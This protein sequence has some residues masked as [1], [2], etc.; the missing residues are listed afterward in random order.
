MLTSKKS[1]ERKHNLSPRTCNVF[2]NT[3]KEMFQLLTED[4]GLIENPFGAIPKLNNEYQQREPF[5]EEELKLIAEQKK[6]N[7]FIYPIFAIG[8]SKALREGDIYTLK[9]SEVDFSRNLITRLIPV[10]Q[11]LFCSKKY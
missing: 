3:L 7:E 9:W 5:T 1:Y 8:I 4:A 2:H 6:A 10:F 11:L